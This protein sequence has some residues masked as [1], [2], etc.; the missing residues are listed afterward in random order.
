MDPKKL[1]RDPARVQACLKEL[2]DG[3][4]VTT[5]GCK[6]YIP[7]R[8]EERNLAEIGSET[9]ICGIFATVVEGTF[10]SVTNVCAMFKIEP[11]STMK[12]MVDG[13]EYYE[14]TFDPGAT[15]MPSLDLVKLDM[16]VY[17]VY[18]EVMSK[19]RVPFYLGYIELSEIFDTAL[20]HAG[21]NIGQNQEVTELI[22]SII[23]RDPSDRTKYYRTCVKDLMDL[24]RNPPAFTPLKSVQFAATN[25]TNKLAG[26]YF[27]EGLVSALVSPAERTERIEGLL[28]K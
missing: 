7:A 16:L 28:R 4:L 14:F 2:P 3:R 27:N 15:V 12:I 10:Y 8:F 1:V 18:D 22:V 9:N 23:S 6:I 11:S 19:G 26:S 21:A 20:E 5:K 24:T 25:T 17:R 13:D